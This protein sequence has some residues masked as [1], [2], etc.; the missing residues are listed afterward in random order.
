MAS[1]TR[2]NYPQAYSVSEA[3]P[4]FAIAVADGEAGLDYKG[5]GMPDDAMML[6]ID[7]VSFF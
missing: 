6:D 3:R 2:L 5:N 1:T 7:W 4:G